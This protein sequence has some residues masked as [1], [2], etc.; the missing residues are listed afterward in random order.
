MEIEKRYAALERECSQAT[1]AGAGSVYH[2]GGVWYSGKELT[3]QIQENPYLQY[4][5]R[6]LGY[7]DESLP[8]DPSLVVYFRKRLTPEIWGEIN[9]MIICDA[10]ERP[11]KEMTTMILATAVGTAGRSL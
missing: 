10:K 3:L 9:E 2:P 8:F 6:Y 5:C 11:E 1:A 7:D 4:F